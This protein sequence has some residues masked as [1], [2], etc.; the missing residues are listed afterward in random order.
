M[1]H[2][3]KVVESAVRRPPNAGKGRKK[4]VPNK[5]TRV[6]KEAIA[7]AAEELGGVDRLVEWARED[8][9]NEQTF[10]GTIYPK[11]LPHQIEGAGPD[12]SILFKTV[13]EAK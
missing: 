4:G 7:L 1:P 5:T 2:D 6:A 11:L 8:P 13:Y 3:S 12:G 9:K 10:W